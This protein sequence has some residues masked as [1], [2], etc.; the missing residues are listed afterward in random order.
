MVDL[1]IHTNFSDGTD[2]WQ[3]VLKKAEEAGLKKISI[4]DHDN[5]EVYFHMI[6]PQKYFSG[7]I[8]TG[9]EMQAYFRGLS[10]EILGYG[11]DIHKMRQ[12]LQGLYLPFEE[13]NRH[14]LT[15]LVEKCKA[16]G[17]TLDEISYNNQRRYAMH[18]V[19]DEIIKHPQ[20]RQLI[21]DEDSWQH[22][23]IFFKRHISN[24]SSPFYVN[25]NDI[26]PCAEKV[27]AVI[28]EAGGKVVLPHIFQYEENAKLILDGLLK[29]LN[30]IEC[31]YPGFTP[32]QSNML[33]AICEKHNLLVTSGSDYHGGNRPGQIGRCT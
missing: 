18:Y 32:E 33:L 23:H 9:I 12:L 21:Q 19:H 22:Y 7:E 25:E 5:C 8:V 11:F 30:G 17:L 13:I 10:I 1:H 27:I 16:M 20:N 2:T 29:D 3:T 24:P 4:T 6:N 28:H 14:E 31:F 15:R 26:I